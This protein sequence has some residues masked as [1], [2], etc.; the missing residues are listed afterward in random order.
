M[1]YDRILVWFRNDLRLGD[2]ETLTRAIQ[3][4]KE[5]IPVYCFDSRQ[6]KSTSLGFAK[7]GAFR[8]QFL[9]ESVA[10]LRQSFQK[11]GGDLVILHG[12]PEQAVPEFAKQLG[13][14]AIYFSKEVAA[15]ERQVDRALEENAFSQGIACESFW[16]STLYHK[17]D[18]PFPIRQTPEVFTQF[19]KEVEK[20]CKIRPSF[21]SPKQISYPGKAVIPDAGELLPLTTYGLEYRKQAQQSW[22][23]VRGGESAAQERLQSYFWEK[24]LLINYKQTR[25]GLI[26][27]DYSS[28]LSPWLALGCISPRSIYEEVKRYEKERVKND[29]TYWL[30]FELIWRDYF[31]LI[32]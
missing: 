13:A 26:G 24:D 22:L 10:D 4:G 31:Q 19:R 27:M 16:Q 1:K 23:D 8:A 29:S 15:E 28:K 30:V 2:N 9:L 18:L 20:G 12:N 21:P 7:T 32:A 6:F 11:I 17:D 14:T 25:N 3:Q 5:I